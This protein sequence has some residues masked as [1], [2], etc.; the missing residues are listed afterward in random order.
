MRVLSDIA[1]GVAAIVGDGMQERDI[2]QIRDQA[3]ER[4]SNKVKDD[5]VSQ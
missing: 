4:I 1:P 5:E 2:D 3:F